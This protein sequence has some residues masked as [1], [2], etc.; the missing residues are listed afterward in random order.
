M[1]IVPTI[2]LLLAF[3]FNE[4]V[5][6]VSLYLG[7]C[8]LVSDSYP[9]K[10]KQ[11]MAAEFM[12]PSLLEFVGT[13]GAWD[14]YTMNKRETSW[15]HFKS[16]PIYS[17]ARW[18]FCVEPPTRDPGRW[19]GWQLV[20]QNL[21]SKSRKLQMEKPN[22]GVLEEPMDMSRMERFSHTPLPGQEAPTRRSCLNCMYIQWFTV[23]L[24]DEC[25]FVRQEIDEL[26]EH[27]RGDK[28]QVQRQGNFDVQRG[29]VWHTDAGKWKYKY[30]WS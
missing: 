4:R 20:K 9:R 10:Q 2:Y 3:K 29:P 22:T 1:L 19:K 25:E 23:C 13:K 15:S 21:S 5:W 6:W 7:G 30:S 17:L 18:E 28:Q 16:C 14:T 8:R 12:R 11:H 27:S 24:N 26:A